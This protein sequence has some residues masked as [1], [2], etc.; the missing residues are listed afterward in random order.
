MAMCARLVCG[1]ALVA[2]L[3]AMVVGAASAGPPF[4][5]D[6]PEPVDYQHWEFYTFSTGTHA[7]GDTSGWLPAF[8]YNYGILPDV[9]LHIIAPL[10]FDAPS[11]GKPQF[12]LGY[13][14]L[15]VKWRFVEEDKNGAMPQVGTFPL[16]ELPTGNPAGTLGTAFL[17][18]WLQKSFGPWTTYGGGGYWINRVAPDDRDYWFFGWLLQ[19]KITDQLTLG[20]EIFHQTSSKVDGV[21][22]T[23]FN[24]G[25]S[26]DLD[27][28]NHLLFSAGRGLQNAAASNLFS[29]YIGYQITQ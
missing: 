28:H 23:S 22:S 21:P 15:G 13:T 7:T 16:V 26:Y 11:D 5:T 3:A 8:E 17:P 2:A 25:G 27:E 18:L 4:V 6:D 1:S 24:V 9:H 29:W 12:G 20:G 10:A 14:E 19:R